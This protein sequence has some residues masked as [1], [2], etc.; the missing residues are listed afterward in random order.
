[1]DIKETARLLR[2]GWLSLVAITLA[3]ISL[4]A[5][6]TLV[7]QPQYV[8]TTDLFVSVKTI[9]ADSAGEVVQGSSAA[10]LKVKSYVQVVRSAAV[11]APVIKELK[12]RDSVA[13]LAA[14]VS[15][16]TP[17]G[18]VLLNVS[19]SDRDPATAAKIANAIGT[20]AAKAVEQLEEVE[21]GAPSPVSIQTVQPASTPTTPSS[22]NLAASLAIAT[23]TGL[24]GG[25]GLL[26]LRDRLDT[27]VH[28]RG[29]LEAMTHSPLVGSIGFDENAN[30]RPLIVHDD[31]RS[32][33]AE[34]FRALR[35]NLQH[36][37]PDNP[38]RTF[39]I[40]S[41]VPSE[42][43]T[44]TSANL[45]IAIAESGASVVLVDAD[46]RRPRLAEMMGVEGA[47]GLTD[48]LAGRAELT[49]LLQPWGSHR[50]SVLPAGTVP[51]NPSE[52]LGS[53]GMKALID[54]L[55]A[56]F[57]YVIIDAPPLLPV[58]D[59]A[60]LSR[61]ASGAILV[62]S[63]RRVRKGQLREALSSLERIGRAPLGIILTMLPQRG[64][65]GYGYG[66][67]SRYYGN[68]SIP[69]APHPDGGRRRG[70]GLDG[71]IAAPPP[72]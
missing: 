41:S 42:G 58:T 32:P 9:E 4:G 1:M 27:R 13:Q 24:L 33:R 26:L 57:R 17:Q 54:E 67:Y 49:D 60:V 15:T 61:F 36:L 56:E 51:P 29:D 45:A 7:A 20:S 35:T 70:G 62:A 48:A 44:T 8:A 25:F 68:E 34:S 50:L 39:V 55:A 64:P 10:Q 47:A 65:E 37:D 46:L 53:E 52:L 5:T 66:A 63:H 28:G 30:E 72:A 59:A 21:G 2:K 18:T 38:D 22:P 14:R 23:A 19:V 16:E 31:P 6:Y 69:Q 11:L 40:T 43:K 12:L 3:A 71:P